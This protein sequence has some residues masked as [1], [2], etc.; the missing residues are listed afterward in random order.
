MDG[1]DTLG[2]EQSLM[3]NLLK[4]IPVLLLGLV[5]VL[6][7]ACG[8]GSGDSATSDADGNGSRNLT[9]DQPDGGAPSDLLISNAT[10]VLGASVQR[11]EQDVESM[12]AEFLMDVDMAGFAMGIEGDFAFESPDKLYM[13]M[14][15]DGGDASLIDFSELG[16]FEVLALGGDFYLNM[17]FLGGWFVMSADDLGT[18]IETFESMFESHSPF[19]YSSLI[20]SVGGDVD[21]LG[22]E[23]MDGGTFHHYRITVDMADAMDAVAQAFGESDTFGFG[24]LPTDTIS[25]PMVMDLWVHPDSF[26]PHRLEADLSIDIEGE[27]ADMVMQFKFFDY[28]KGGGIPA[29]PKDA[30]NFAELF[31]GLFEDD[32]S[33]SFG[34]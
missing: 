21:D 22:E 27:T 2:Q 14:T 20:D 17:P 28:N 11:F 19:D 29:P 6:A 25:G 13:T 18:E 23:S 24:D 7:V 4:T 3:M 1:P 32:F 30:Q 31:E 10:D 9:S 5:L 8:G 12:R 15:M 16:S 33:F 26:L 34:E